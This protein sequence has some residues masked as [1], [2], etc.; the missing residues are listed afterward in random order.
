M[1]GHLYVIPSYEVNY[2]QNGIFYRQDLGEK[3]GVDKIDSMESLEA[4]MD[5]VAKNETNV[6]PIDGNPEQALFQLFKSYYGFESIA[7]SNTSIVMVRGLR[8]H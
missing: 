8:R 5:A 4:Y 7:G 1:D 3:Y 2:N 6:R